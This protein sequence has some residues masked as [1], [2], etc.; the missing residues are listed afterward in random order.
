[1]SRTP[2]KYTHSKNVKFTKIQFETLKKLESYNIR[3]CDFIR[4][5]VAEKIQRDKHEIIK[6]KKEQKCPF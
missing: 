6:P 3:V 5:A 2:L 4:D 1:M